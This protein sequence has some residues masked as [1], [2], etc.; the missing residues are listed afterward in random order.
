MSETCGL[1][2]PSFAHRNGNLPGSV[3]TWSAVRGQTDFLLDEVAGGWKVSGTNV[4]YSAFPVTVT[5]PANYSNQVF[6]Y[7]GAARPDQLN[8]VSFT[9]VRSPTGSAPTIPW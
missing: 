7:T 1:R 5:S 6:A 3:R 2:Y 4:T 9:T 8:P